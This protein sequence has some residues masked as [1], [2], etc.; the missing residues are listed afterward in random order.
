MNKRKIKYKKTEKPTRRDKTCFIIGN[1]DS[2]MRYLRFEELMGDQLGQ[3]SANSRAIELSY[4]QGYDY[5]F[6][7]ISTGLSD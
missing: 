6:L 4:N 2:A 5:S 7:Q 3:R 1:F